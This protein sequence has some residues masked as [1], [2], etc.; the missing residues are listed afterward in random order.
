[1]PKRQLP[2]DSSLEWALDGIDTS[3]DVILQKENK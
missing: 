1:M 2:C 3:K